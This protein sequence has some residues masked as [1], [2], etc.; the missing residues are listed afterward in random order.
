MKSTLVLVITVVILVMV[1][2]PRRYKPNMVR[3][4]FVFLVSVMAIFP[5]FKHESRSLSI[6]KLVISLYAKGMSASDIEDELRDIYEVNLSTS[7]ISIITNKAT[8]FALE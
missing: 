1:A 4:P 5:L 7:A 3:V 8:Q 6:E 2:F